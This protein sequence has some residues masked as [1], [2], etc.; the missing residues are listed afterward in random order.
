MQSIVMKQKVD[1]DV[2]CMKEDGFLMIYILY[3]IQLTAP[4]LRIFSTA[5]RMVDLT[6]F[7]SNIDGSHLHVTYQGAFN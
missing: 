3:T 6:N 7:T 2:I 1:Q 5:K 4:S